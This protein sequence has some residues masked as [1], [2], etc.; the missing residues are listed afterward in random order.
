MEEHEKKE[1]AVGKEEFF[2]S[3]NVMYSMTL[4]L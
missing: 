2:G 3:T 4:L 1:S